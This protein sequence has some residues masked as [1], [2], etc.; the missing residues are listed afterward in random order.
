[1]SETE[2]RKKKSQPGKWEIYWLNLFGGWFGL[3]KLVL[4]LC[5]YRQGG[6]WNFFNITKSYLWLF[7]AIPGMLWLITQIIIMIANSTQ[8]GDY[9]FQKG[10]FRKHVIPINHPLEIF[11]TYMI[12]FALLTSALTIIPM[13]LT[14]LFRLKPG[15]NWFTDLFYVGPKEGWDDHEIESENKIVSIIGRII[16]IIVSLNILFWF[17]ILVYRKW[18]E[19]WAEKIDAARYKKNPYLV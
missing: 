3:D 16:A 13:Q 14:V 18:L 8:I 15:T 17:F 12:N 7:P 6:S 1:M 2:I 9:E 5:D 4:W 11:A 10:M 19:N